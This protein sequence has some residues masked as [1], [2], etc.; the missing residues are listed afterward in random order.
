MSTYIYESPAIK[1]KSSS[2]ELLEELIG[3]DSHTNNIDG[4]KRAQ[5]FISDKLK[6]LGFEVEIVKNHQGYPLLIAQKKGI[7]AD[8]I[9]LIA[10]NDTVAKLNRSPFRSDGDYLFG[11]GI[12]DDKAGVIIGL[13][14]LKKYIGLEPNHKYSLRFIISPNEETGS[15]GFHHLF[16]EIGRRS[17]YLLGLEPADP[18]GRII[19]SR[20]GNRWYKLKTKGIAAHAGRFGESHLNATHELSQIISSLL[21]LNSEKEK[22]RINF[23]SLES[24]D[25]SYNTICH[26]ILAKCDVRFTSFEQRDFIHQKMIQILNTPHEQCPYQGHQALK[27]YCI[28]DDCPPLAENALNYELATIASKLISYVEQREVSSFHS[29]GAADINYLANPS[30]IG[31]DGLGAVGG[32]LHTTKEYIER[33]SLLSR[34]QSLFS[35]IDYINSQVYDLYTQSMH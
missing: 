32:G 35:L 4:I 29:G 31:I 34:S 21:K 3:I 14:A 30:N 15:Q 28:E 10:H 2:F 22:T 26:E 5:D 13:E 23:G 12:A 17:K 1:N 18:H 8:Y 20:S 11:A 24:T 33:S 25:K 19:H 16:S 6:V 27:F 9:T 7:L